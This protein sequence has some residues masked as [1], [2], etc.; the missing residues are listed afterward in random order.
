MAAIP[1]RSRA[2]EPTYKGGT[3][4]AVACE[5]EEKIMERAAIA[6]SPTGEVIMSEEI[7]RKA[8]RHAKEFADDEVRSGRTLYSTWTQHTSTC[9]N[10]LEAFYKRLTELGVSNGSTQEPYRKRFEKDNGIGD[11]Y[12][13]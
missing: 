7:Y 12:F 8:K 13:A 2:L 6:Q 5:R 3:D 4:L 10:V 9:A 11:N 1:W